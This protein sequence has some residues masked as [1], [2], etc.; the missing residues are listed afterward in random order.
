VELDE[1]RQ[2]RVLIRAELL[3]GEP[4]EAFPDRHSG[5]LKV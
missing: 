1:R 2:P 5:R 3:L 4:A